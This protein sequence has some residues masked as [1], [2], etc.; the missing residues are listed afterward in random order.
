[1]DDALFIRLSEGG[2]DRVDHVEPDNAW[3]RFEILEGGK[4]YAKAGR[5]ELDIPFTQAR[6][7]HLLSYEAYFANTGYESDSI[8]SYQEGIEL[9][10]EFDRSTRWSAAVVKGRNDPAAEALSDAASDFDAN[11][12]LRVARRVERNRFGTFAYVGRNTLATQPAAGPVLEWND[13]LLRL[14]ADADVWLRKLNLYGVFLY[15]RNDNAI[16]TPSQPN[17]T[18]EATSFTSGFV[19][20]DYH[21]SEPVVLTLRFNA[22]SRPPD[23]LGTS[24]ETFTALVPGLQ[25]FL[26]EHGKLS[27]EYG[28]FNKERSGFGAVQI[29]A[30]F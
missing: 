26:F 11:V 20:A 25:F 19:Q 16:A 12:F 4:L 7:S 21:L 5:M 27:F 13:N 23:A 10:G 24:K 9:G 30:A 28:F 18:E 14:G 6:T 1:V 17:G 8:A 15:G 22:V 29:E 2:D 3:L